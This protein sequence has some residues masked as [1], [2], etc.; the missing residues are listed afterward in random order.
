MANYL[1]PS[2]RPHSKGQNDLAYRMERTDSDSKKVESAD[3]ETRTSA[4]YHVLKRNREGTARGTRIV[5]LVRFVDPLESIEFIP[6][7]IIFS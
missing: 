3:R 5:T 7:D 6:L 4:I 2:L 1:N